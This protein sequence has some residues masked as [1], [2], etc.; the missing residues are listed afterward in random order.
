MRRL[1]RDRRGIINRH[2]PLRRRIDKDQFHLAFQHPQQ[3]PCARFGAM[4]V[5]QLVRQAV[6]VK[7]RRSAIRSDWLNSIGH[8]T[9]ARMTAKA[10]AKTANNIGTVKICA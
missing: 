7:Y 3:A 1:G 4:L 8:Q 2:Q 6:F 9:M 10:Q 5:A